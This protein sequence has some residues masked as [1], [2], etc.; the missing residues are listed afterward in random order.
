MP[1]RVLVALQERQ[2]F[3]QRLLPSHV[4]VCAQTEALVR[5][6]VLHNPLTRHRN[7]VK[8]NGELGLSG[9]YATM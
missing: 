7:F 6:L 1:P 8:H 9:T 3:G 5:D 2:R 4:V